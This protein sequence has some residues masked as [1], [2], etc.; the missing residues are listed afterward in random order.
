[1]AA[2]RAIKSSITRPL[3]PSRPR[4][5]QMDAAFGVA[6]ARRAGRPHP[7]LVGPACSRPGVP[8]GLV[9]A[10]EALVP[11][12]PPPEPRAGPVRPGS[13]RPGAGGVPGAPIAP[14]A[15]DGAVP[16]DRAGVS[17]GALEGHG[18]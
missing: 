3:C 17:A 12:V 8:D 7:V 15:R 9:T 14:G 10:D 6:A 16:A 13:E 2:I 1:M 18:S 4:P 11:L 5:A